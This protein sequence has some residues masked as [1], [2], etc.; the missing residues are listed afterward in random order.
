MMVLKLLS[1]TGNKS[2]DADLQSASI[3]LSMPFNFAQEL[4]TDQLTHNEIHQQ[5][6][7]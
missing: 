7:K 4:N 3:V 2:A 1:G 5:R 6:Q